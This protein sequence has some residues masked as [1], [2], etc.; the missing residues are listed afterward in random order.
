MRSRLARYRRDM[1]RVATTSS[2][3]FDGRDLS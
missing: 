1:R 2:S 3:D